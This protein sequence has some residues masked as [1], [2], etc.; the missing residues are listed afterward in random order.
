MKEPSRL[1]KIVLVISILI[2]V[3]TVYK[4]GNKLLNVYNVRQL[5]IPSSSQ[6]YLM[7]GWLNFA[8]QTV[9]ESEIPKPILHSD[10][11]FVSDRTISNDFKTQAVVSEDKKVFI[12]EGVLPHPNLVISDLSGNEVKTI[13]L[14][15][16]KKVPGYSLYFSNDGHKLAL[17]SQ[18]QLEIVDIDSKK[19]SKYPLNK[20]INIACQKRSE[21]DDKDKCNKDFSFYFFKS[22]G[23]WLSERT[24]IFNIYGYLFSIDLT[25]NSISLISGIDHVSKFTVLDSNKLA[26]V[27]MPNWESKISLIRIYDVSK[28]EVV[29]VYPNLSMRG[30]DFI[31]SSPNGKFLL[32]GNF[33]CSPLD[34][35]CGGPSRV[36]ARIINLDTGK[37]AELIKNHHYKQNS[38]K[39][40]FWLK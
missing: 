32:V 8:D 10:R 18:Q 22:V 1:I 20:A 17:F 12:Y 5:K 4:F 24:I 15:Y 6:L 3:P 26:Y 23:N 25:S 27:Y 9:N 29:K 21:S 11:R 34:V 31:E 39:E 30:S 40:I 7:N 16:L 37:S 19:I 28:Q 14:E 13:P 35:D 36:T 33:S 38:P 2:I